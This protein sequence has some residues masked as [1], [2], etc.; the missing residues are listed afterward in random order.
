MASLGGIA[1]FDRAS[2]LSNG[3][4]FR[5]VAPAKV[6][7]SV[8]VAGGHVEVAEGQADVVARF[9]GAADAEATL[10]MGHRLAQEGLDLLSVLGRT[11]SVIEDA[12][13]EYLLWWPTK[14]GPTMRLVSTAVLRFSVGPATLVAR[15]KEGREVLPHPLQPIHHVGFRYY[16]L[17]QI[18]DDLYDAY[19][20][21]YLAFEVLLSSRI[22][23][24]K[25]E[26]E[27]E[28]LRRGLSDSAIRLDGLGFDDETDQVGEIIGAVYREAR[29][30]LFHAKEGR[31]FYPPQE[32]G[33]SR[34]KISGA[35]TILTRL[36]LR[37]AESWYEARRLGGGVYFGWVYENTR[38]QLE[39]CY[40][41]ATNFS[42][43]FDPDEDDLSHDR[44]ESGVR[45]D[46]RLAPE[47]ERRGEPAV[48][49]E[50]DAEDLNRIGKIRRIELM[51]PEH[52]YM[53]QLLDSPLTCEYA[54]RFE[55]VTHVR[56]ANANQPKSLFRR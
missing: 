51:A 37:M 18:T 30:P 41:I 34:D 19:R 27:I 40:M 23:M 6:N 20:N 8:E 28:W 55:V 16:R 5:L 36:V 47:L 46:L 53:A 10:D 2:L 56:G 25:G 7:A 52:P 13:D 44:F 45:F 29:L 4:A 3:A 50:V 11:D 17:A 35:L 21:M 43:P 22:P 1:L 26:R 54:A 12:E 24:Q 31:D 39:R 14:A 32:S 38:K 9:S 48:I 42:G 15:D 49:G 33:E